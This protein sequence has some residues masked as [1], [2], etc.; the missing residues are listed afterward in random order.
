MGFFIFYF[1]LGFLTG[2]QNSIE[3]QAEAMLILFRVRLCS[4]KIRQ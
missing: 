1:A 3:L 2:A 4:E